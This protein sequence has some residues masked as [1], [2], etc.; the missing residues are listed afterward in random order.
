[1]LLIL[2]VPKL[3]QLGSTFSIVVRGRV[4][5]PDGQGRL[6]W[7]AS[8]DGDWGE[9]SSTTPIRL[10]RFFFESDKELRIVTGVSAVAL[11]TFYLKVGV[12]HDKEGKDPDFTTDV[13]CIGVLEEKDLQPKNDGEDRFGY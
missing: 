2:S 3:V 11:G 10:E 7:A 1:M 4:F 6:L 13:V 12:W 8:E 9:C 5:A